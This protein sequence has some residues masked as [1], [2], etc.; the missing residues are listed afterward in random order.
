MV[1]TFG[2]QRI[3]NVIE[4]SLTGGYLY[5]RYIV[6]NEIAERYEKT[7]YIDSFKVTREDD[8]EQKRTDK[9]CRKLL[10]DL[11]LAYK[12]SKDT[13]DL[14]FGSDRFEYILSMDPEVI[15]M[16]AEMCRKRYQ[17]AK[18]ATQ[19]DSDAEQA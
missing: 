3:E 16:D 5:I 19:S 6:G 4:Y 11:Y 10:S 13:R 1:I 18:N 2:G 15:S 14:F 7:E 17:N 12:A 9:A 8:E